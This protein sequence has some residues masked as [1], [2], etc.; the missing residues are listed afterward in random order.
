MEAEP[1]FSVA[2][3]ILIR[4]LVFLAVALAVSRKKWKSEAEEKEILYHLY[5]E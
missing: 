2:V 1:S 3:S 5:S 4:F